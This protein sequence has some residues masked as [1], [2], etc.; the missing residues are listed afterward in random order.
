MNKMAE[1]LSA[2]M[3]EDELMQ[4]IQ[5]HYLGEA[6]LLTSGAEDNLLKLA[7]LRGN[8]TEEQ[9]SRWEEIKRDFLRNKAMGG[10]DGDVGGKVVAQLVDLVSGIKDLKNVAETAT[11]RELAELALQREIESQAMQVEPV[12]NVSSDQFSEEMNKLISALEGNQPNVE[13][14]N[15]PVPGIDRILSALAD[16]IEH[17]LT[18]VVKSMDKKLDIDLRTHYKLRDVSKQ[19]RNLERASGI[20]PTVID[21]DS[22]DLEG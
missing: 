3:N 20:N 13:V 7:E 16:T 12:D 2:V 14:V 17:S 22:T 11:E 10:D 1:K 15:Q 5:D 4:M 6:Q 18:P 21:S 9:S 8:M 19:L